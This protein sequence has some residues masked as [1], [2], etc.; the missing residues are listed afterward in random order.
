MSDLKIKIAKRRGK[1]VTPDT[2]QL[3]SGSKCGCVCIGCD[4]PLVLKRGKIRQSHFSHPPRTACTIHDIVKGWIAQALPGQILT[5][6]EHPGLIAPRKFLV[7]TD[8]AQVEFSEGNRRYDVRLEVMPIMDFKRAI[9]PEF[10]EVFYRQFDKYYEPFCGGDVEHDWLL[11]AY[12]MNRNKIG[13]QKKTDWESHVPM[14]REMLSFFGKIAAYASGLNERDF[15]ESQSH[16]AR[17]AKNMFRPQ[18]LPEFYAGRK[19]ASKKMDP[20][21]KDRLKERT[22]SPESRDHI[23]IEVRDT[24]AKDDAF[25]KQVQDEKRYVLE[26]DANK[27]YGDGQG[28]T[29]E[30]LLECSEWVWPAPAEEHLP[31]KGPLSCLH[32]FSS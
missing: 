31:F 4:K 5:L 14:F 25:K 27:F 12:L 6:P 26:V 16:Q 13:L 22:P 2:P 18:I 8:G 11:T 1:L 21:L 15:K 30:K 17:M 7:C 9:V 3:D 19:E 20:K 10:Y 29:I 23:M 24:N 32:S 28:L